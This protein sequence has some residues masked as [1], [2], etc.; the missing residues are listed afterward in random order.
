[1]GGDSAV[2][3]AWLFAAAD[4]VFVS[5]SCSR[6][7]RPSARLRAALAQRRGT[8]VRAGQLKMPQSSAR[9]ALQLAA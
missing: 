5:S 6:P 9:K 2:G 8:G 3:L 4:I 7:S 1:M